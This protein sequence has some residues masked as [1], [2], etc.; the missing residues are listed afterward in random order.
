MTGAAV[1]KCSAKVAPLAEQCCR[2]RLGFGSQASFCLTAFRS[3]VGIHAVVAASSQKAPYLCSL[4][5][6]E[7]CFFYELMAVIF[8]EELSPILLLLLGVVA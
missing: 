1:A 3:G 5:E 6:N 2:G 8:R 4:R 7:G